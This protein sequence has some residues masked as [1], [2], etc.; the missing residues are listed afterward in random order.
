MFKGTRNSASDSAAPSRKSAL[1]ASLQMRALEPRVLLDAAAVTVATTVSE[2][3]APAAAEPAQDANHELMAALAAN[4][5]VSIPGPTEQRSATQPADSAAHA[6]SETQPVTD[7]QA[8]VASAQSGADS[9]IQVYFVD[10]A[11]ADSQALIASFGPDAEVHVLQ[12]GQDGVE[13]IAQT[14]AGRSDIRAIHVFSHST[15]G[16]LQLGS[17]SL[18]A[19]S[20]QAEYSDELASIGLSLSAE[21]DILLYGCDFAAGPA[22]EQSVALLAALTGADVAASIDDT[23]AARWGGDW[24]LEYATGSIEALAI[25]AVDWDHLLAP[26]ELDLNGAGAG[27]DVTANNTEGSFVLI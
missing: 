8:E 14:L 24:Q 11:V 1:A 22:G 26:P 10:S 7:T 20:M 13:Q 19:A 18:N 25:S 3:S 9:G 23:G 27:V 6:S 5:A 17:A 15:V 12:A 2:Q 16:Q 21:G 4:P